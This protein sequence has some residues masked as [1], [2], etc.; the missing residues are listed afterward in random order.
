MIE[1]IA[2]ISIIAPIF[3]Y[4]VPMVVADRRNHRNTLAISMLN[5]FL[6]WTVLG[7]ILALV[8]AC[9]D[10]VNRPLPQR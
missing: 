10:N 5:L 1:V 8:W 6:G 2:V 7:W 4:I 9:T 3:L